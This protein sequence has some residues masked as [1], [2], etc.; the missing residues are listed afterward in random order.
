MTPCKVQ[1]L[2][3]FFGGTGNLVFTLPVPRFSPFFII[4]WLQFFG[5]DEITEIASPSILIT[6]ARAFGSNQLHRHLAPTFYSAFAA[7]LSLPFLASCFSLPDQCTWS[8][9]GP[10]FWPYVQQP[11]NSIVQLVAGR[12]KVRPYTRDTFFWGH[13]IAILIGDCSHFLPSPIKQTLFRHFSSLL[14]QDS[15][16]NSMCGLSPAICH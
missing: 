12:P 6:S 11:R 4:S 16:Q 14:K 10:S 1:N 13:R 5:E 7:Q 9:S 8:A 3:L 15:E 2:Q